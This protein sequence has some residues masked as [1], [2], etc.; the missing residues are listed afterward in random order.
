[1]LQQVEH[2]TPCRGWDEAGTIAGTA[3]VETTTAVTGNRLRELELAALAAALLAPRLK[4]GESDLLG[5]LAHCST[6]SSH[7]S[8]VFAYACLM[9]GDWLSD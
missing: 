8:S 9:D 2:L 6:F 4:N 7:E 3:S 1:M 5:L